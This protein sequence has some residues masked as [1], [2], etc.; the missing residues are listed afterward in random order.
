M[1]LQFEQAVE[2]MLPLKYPAEGR[3]IELGL[4]NNSNKDEHD[5]F[6]LFEK[7]HLRFQFTQY[8][9]ARLAHGEVPH[10]SIFAAAPIPLL[11]E[12]GRLLSDIPAAE[13]YQYHREPQTWAWQRH[14]GKFNFILRT[15]KIRCKTAA[16]NLSLSATIDNSRITSV[17]GRRCSIWTLAIPRPS[18]DFLKSRRQLQMFREQFRLLLDRIKKRHGEDTCI[19][20]FPAVPVAVAVEIGRVWMPKADLPIKIYDQNRKRGGFRFAFDLEQT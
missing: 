3:A 16:V 19:H 18:N 2:A 1:P 17:L 6:W 20:L 14:Q 4:Q 10:L 11:M 12:L 7:K 8:L 15:P 13:I 9:K 5:E